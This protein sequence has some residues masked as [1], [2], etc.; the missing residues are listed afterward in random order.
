MN[1]IEQK[2]WIFC[3]IG[4]QE[5]HLSLQWA[6]VCSRFRTSDRAE[7]LTYLKV[8]LAGGLLMNCPMIDALQ[9]AC[10]LQVPCGGTVC[11]VGNIHGT[12]VMVLAND[13]TV[14]VWDLPCSLYTTS[15]PE[16]RILLVFPGCGSGSGSK[17]SSIMKKLGNFM[18]WKPGIRNLFDPGSGIQ[19]GIPDPQH[20]WIP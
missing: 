5:F 15:V 7:L 3:W 13:G 10:V 17:C 6:C 1:S 9:F 2:T 11:G 18:Y 8:V 19:V 12:Q 16:H 20:C 4:V 14:K